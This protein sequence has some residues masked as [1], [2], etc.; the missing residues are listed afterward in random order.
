ML[1]TAGTAGAIGDRGGQEQRLSAALGGAPVSSVAS[2]VYALDEGAWL[3]VAGADGWGGPLELAVEVCP[4]GTITALHLLD[5]VETAAFLARVER[6]GFYEQL[7]GRSV[8]DPLVA[9]QDVDTISGATLSTEGLTRAAR[10][11][12]HAVATQAMGLEPP[13][14]P[15]PKPRVGWQELSVAGLFAFAGLAAGRGWTRLRWGS[16]IAGL[17]LLGFLLAA[18]PSLSM[19]ASLLLGAPPSPLA[20]PLWWLALLGPFLLVLTTRR[21]VYCSWLC[22]F[23]ALQDVQAAI[24]GRT[25]RVPNRLARAGPR[26]ALAVTVVALAWA[27]LSRSPD[28]AGFEPFGTLFARVGEAW[29]W[30]LMPAVLLVG[31]AIKRPW[32]R[33]LCPVGALLGEVQRGSRAARGSGI[34][35]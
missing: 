5:H 9:H 25:L 7:E 28:A 12:S 4:D 18:P 10:H 19:V 27:L 35:G 21:N 33:F 1:A 17:A 34:R 20:R 23:G 3:G 16:R 11:A 26:L 6:K 2:G 31:F 14:E 15:R 29:D 32:C 30:F 22:P 24:T 8:L 13:P